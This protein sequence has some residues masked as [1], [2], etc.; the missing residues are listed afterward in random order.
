MS[1]RNRTTVAAL[2]LLAILAVVVLVAF[3]GNSCPVETVLQP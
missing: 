2:L 3:A 1:G